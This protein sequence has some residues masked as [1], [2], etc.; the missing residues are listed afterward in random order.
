VQTAAVVVGGLVLV[1]LVIGLF[2][3][4]TLNSPGVL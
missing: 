3:F 4:L 1:L 2:V